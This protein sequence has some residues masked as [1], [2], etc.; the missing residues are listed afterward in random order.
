MCYMRLAEIHDA[1][2]ATNSPY[3]IAHRSPN[4]T[5][6]LAVSWVG[7]LYIHIRCSCSWQNVA[8]Y[9]IQFTSES[10][11][12]LYWQRYCTA[13]QQ[14]ASAKL[15]GVVQ[16]MKLQNFRTWAP[17]MRRYCPCYVMLALLI[18][19]VGDFS[20]CAYSANQICRR[21]AMHVI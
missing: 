19:I 16:G 1:K 18:A 4:C 2:I 15:C 5:R 12:L 13:R 6:C 11:V 14:R 9:K 7:R 20:H 17:P 8:R 10:C 3:A 21:I